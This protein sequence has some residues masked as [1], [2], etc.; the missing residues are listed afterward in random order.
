[1]SAKP[2]TLPQAPEA[3]FLEKLKARKQ[4]ERFFP[5]WV[6]LFSHPSYFVNRGLLT[7]FKRFAPL[8]KGKLLDY[9]CG[10]KPY[11]EI[12]DNPQY[13]GVDINLPGGHDHSNEQIDFYYDG[14]TLPFQDASFDAV[15]SS[16]VMEHIFNMNES[17]QEINRV[18]KPGGKLLFSTPFIFPEHEQP[19]DFARYSTFG[20]QHLLE[21]HGFKII[22]HIQIGHATQAILQLWT[23]YVSTSWFTKSPL[24]N[25]ISRLIFVFPAN[26]LG[27]F[28]PKVLPNTSGFF[29]SHVV[30]AEKIRGA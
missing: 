26:L 11:R 15:F 3:T 16:E 14:T 17:L 23:Y 24:L 28:L 19:Y 4:R 21:H 25:W 8:M 20:L 22:E 5:T 10:S 7:Q 1:M 12:F 6:S 30:L 2:S 29:A 9:G 27:L 18:L 13:I